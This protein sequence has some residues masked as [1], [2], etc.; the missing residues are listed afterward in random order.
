MKRACSE[1]WCEAN[2]KDQARKLLV[3]GSFDKNLMAFGYILYWM[4]KQNLTWD[5]NTQRVYNQS[6]SH[7][8]Y[9]EAVAHPTFKRQWVLCSCRLFHCTQSDMS[10]SDREIIPHDLNHSWVQDLRGSAS[11][12]MMKQVHVVPPPDLWGKMNTSSIHKQNLN[13]SWCILSPITSLWIDPLDRIL[14]QNYNYGMQ[15]A[16]CVWFD[17]GTHVASAPSRNVYRQWLVA[18]SHLLNQ[19]SEVLEVHKYFGIF[20][21]SISTVAESRSCIWTP[22]C[23]K[24]RRQHH[25]VSGL[26]TKELRANPCCTVNKMLPATSETKRCW[27]PAIKIKNKLR[28]TVDP[29]ESLALDTTIGKAIHIHSGAPANQSDSWYIVKRG[30]L[31]PL[32]VWTHDPVLDSFGLVSSWEKNLQSN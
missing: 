16:R 2:Q 23:R 9:T 21:C 6:L 12:S 22:Q 8:Q 18:S 15:I 31:V 20:P 28:N 29:V 17:C 13:P 27:N 24:R 10:N 4:G 26:N 19:S 1:R 11:T 7:C 14:A 32:R 25:P 30:K 5:D 3:K